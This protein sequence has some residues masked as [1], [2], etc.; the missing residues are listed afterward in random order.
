M[1][2]RSHP[3]EVRGLQ[4]EEA[5]ANWSEDSQSFFVFR[6]D[7]YP[8]KI[9]KLNAFTGARR[10]IREIIPEDPVGLDFLYSVRV[11]RDEHNIAYSYRRSFSELYLVTGLR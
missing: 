11:S 4:P 7:V 6:A 10:V 8:V 1:P 9:V 3:R 2:T 5:F